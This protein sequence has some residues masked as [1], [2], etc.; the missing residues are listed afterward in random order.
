M[1]PECWYQS[2]AFIKDTSTLNASAGN[3]QVCMCRSGL[4]S[5]TII[6]VFP[7]WV[8][9]TW[10]AD[11]TTVGGSCGS[12]TKLFCKPHPFSLPAALPVTSCYCGYLTIPAMGGSL[13][14]LSTGYL[15]R[16][17]K[18]PQVVSPAEVPSLASVLSA[19]G[20]HFK[21]L[22]VGLETQLR[23]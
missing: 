23:G 14:L 3:V 4:E 5:K 8:R 6:G 16:R 18:H 17:R 7:E 15:H 20:G 12:V 13:S 2:E 19:R 1:S 10:H 11:N 22:A 21:I 9:K